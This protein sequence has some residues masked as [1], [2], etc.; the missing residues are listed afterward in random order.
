M[1]HIHVQSRHITTHLMFQPCQ[2]LYHPVFPSHSMQQYVLHMFSSACF[3][4]VSTRIAFISC[5]HLEDSPITGIIT[6]IILFISGEHFADLPITVHL[7]FS[8]TSA[9]T[10][11]PCHL[12]C[13]QHRPAQISIQSGNGMKSGARQTSQSSRRYCVRMLFGGVC[14]HMRHRSSHRRR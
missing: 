6:R 12:A 11:L 5:F 2:Q 1:N 10:I 3:R 4:T 7:T 8:S 13:L 9:W 14:L